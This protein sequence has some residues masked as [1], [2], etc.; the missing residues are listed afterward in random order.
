M[1]A[2]IYF[3]EMIIILC[4]LAIRWWLYFYAMRE[5]GFW[6]NK[7]QST[8]ILGYFRLPGQAF[9]VTISDYLFCILIMPAIALLICILLYMLFDYPAY[10][11]GKL[12]D[13]INIF[14]FYG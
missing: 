5:I 7:A 6:V 3:Y 1:N 11:S 4:V 10:Q 14:G 2:D 9:I 12:D 13:A 8:P